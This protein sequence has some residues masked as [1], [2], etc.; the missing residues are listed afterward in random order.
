MIFGCLLIDVTFILSFIIVKSRHIRTPNT[1]KYKS[2]DMK[3]LVL[4][5]KQVGPLSQAIRAAKI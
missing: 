4:R 5:T 3:I 1:K 2:H